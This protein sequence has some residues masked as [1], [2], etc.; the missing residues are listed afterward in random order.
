MQPSDTGTH[1]PWKVL[2]HLPS[3]PP[4]FNPHTSVPACGQQQLRF[5]FSVTVLEKLQGLML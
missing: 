4:Y 2:E 5:G 3:T 1:S